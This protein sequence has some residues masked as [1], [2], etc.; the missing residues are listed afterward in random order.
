[1]YKHILAAVVIVVSLVTIMSYFTYVS[2][3]NEKNPT[4]CSEIPLKEFRDPC[5]AS[6]GVLKLDRELCLNAENP[7]EMNRCLGVVDME[8]SLCE[9]ISNQNSKD[10]CY[11]YLAFRTWN[12]MICDLVESNEKRAECRQNCPTKAPSN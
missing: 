2:A 5:Y 1:M 12:P 8:P 7:D 3:V 6:L 4:K 11:Y 10:F 9:K